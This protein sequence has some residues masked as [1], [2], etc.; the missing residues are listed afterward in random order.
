MLIRQKMMCAVSAAAL[1]SIVNH[2]STL[3]RFSGRVV[4]ESEEAEEEM[5]L[6]NNFFA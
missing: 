3:K 5:A 1:E 2:E 4:P 6:L